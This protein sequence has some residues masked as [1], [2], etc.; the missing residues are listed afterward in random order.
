MADASAGQPELLT[1]LRDE[2]RESGPMTFA[3]FMELALHH[4]SYGYYA[5]GPLRLGRGGDFFTASDVGTAF[6][7]CLARQLVEMDALLDH[8]TTF[9]YV[10]YGAGR[11]L[12]AR[13][14]E[15]AL[16]AEAPDLAHRFA[17]S[18]VDTSPGMRAAAV[19]WMPGAAV[20][21]AASPAA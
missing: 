11:G 14:V 19:S 20:T 4:E 12:L 16:H 6:G 3:R 7:A 9:H 21:A 10:E 17:S 13:D 5:S 8:P 2:I 15:G 18:L 1:L